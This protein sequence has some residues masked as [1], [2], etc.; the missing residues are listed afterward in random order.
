MG[1]Y[2]THSDLQACT[3]QHRHIF[4]LRQ[5]VRGTKCNFEMYFEYKHIHSYFLGTSAP[6]CLSSSL[7]PS[8]FVV[9]LLAPEEEK[10][11]SKALVYCCSLVFSS[12]D[13]YI[14]LEKSS[15]L[16]P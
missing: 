11:L 15:L 6:S 2:V 1:A 8:S 10:G 12:I 7:L 3:L 14:S 9:Y 5:W 4:T 16:F 13:E